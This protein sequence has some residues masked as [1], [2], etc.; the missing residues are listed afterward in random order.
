MSCR[1]RICREHRD[2]T[3]TV[4]EQNGRIS[5]WRVGVLD[6]EKQLRGDAHYLHFCFFVGVSLAAGEGFEP[7]LTDPELISSRLPLFADASKTPYVSRI[8]ASHV[9]GRSPVFAPVTVKSLSKLLWN[10]T[11]RR[12]YRGDSATVTGTPLCA[13]RM[14]SSARAMTFAASPIVTSGRFASPRMRA[15]KW[16]SSSRKAPYR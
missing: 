14:S 3:A 9:S 2:R 12:G 6:D 5:T 4:H 8:L 13:E 10:V 15:K 16:S 11:S 7:S 1:C